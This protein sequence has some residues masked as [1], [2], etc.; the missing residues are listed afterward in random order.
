MKN[1]LKVGDTLFLEYYQRWAKTPSYRKKTVERVTPKYA[2]LKGGIYIDRDPDYKNEYPERGDKIN[3]WSLP[4]EE[5]IKKH[6]EYIEGIR[7]K[8]WWLDFKDKATT[9]QISQ[10]YSIINKE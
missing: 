1:R 7:I 6:N 2:V 8:N 3:S 5:L 4:T 10:I 9:E